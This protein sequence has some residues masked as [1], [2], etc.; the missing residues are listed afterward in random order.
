M[1]LYLRRKDGL[2]PNIINSSGSV[3][4]AKLHFTVK[5]QLL[6]ST[7]EYDYCKKLSKICEN[8]IISIIVIRYDSLYMFTYV[9]NL[10]FSDIKYDYQDVQSFK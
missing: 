9:L 10:Q 2:F 1:P 5:Q 8:S 3:N 4:T 7:T 6:E